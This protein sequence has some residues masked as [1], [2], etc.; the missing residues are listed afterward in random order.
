MTWICVPCTVKDAPVDFAVS[1][2]GPI[3]VTYTWEEEYAPEGSC[4]HMYTSDLT[5]EDQVKQ[6]ETD[7]VSNFKSDWLDRTGAPIYHMSIPKHGKLPDRVT[8][9]ALMGTGD[10]ITYHNVSAAYTTAIDK[11]TDKHNI[12]T[13]YQAYTRPS[14]R[15]S[16]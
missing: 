6:E 4:P 16:Y 11:H 7:N 2:T 14:Y 8:N 15:S 9:I 13:Q 1:T 10:N 5:P 12:S 3:L